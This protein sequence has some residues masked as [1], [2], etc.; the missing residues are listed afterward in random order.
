[1]PEAEVKQPELNSP[2]DEGA[3][4]N[5]PTNPEP[6][7]E[8]NQEEITSEV[9]DPVIA[10]KDKEI[11]EEKIINDKPDQP[12]A[13]P[14][15]TPKPIQDTP[16]EKKKAPEAIFANK[17]SENLFNAIKAGRKEDALKILSEQDRLSKLDNMKPEEKIKLN[18]QYQNKDFSPQEIEDLFEERYS[19]PEAPVQEP[20]ETDEEF[21]IVE[22]KYKEQLAR[23]ERKIEREAKASAT[24]LKKYAQELVLP[25]I[26][27]EA[28]AFKEPTQEELQMAQKQA[29][30]SLKAI[31]A[32]LT[33][34]KG[35]N[36]TF[37]DEEVE[38]PVAYKVT[39]QEKEDLKPLLNS[40]NTDLP[41]F[42]Q[43]LGWFDKDGKLDTNKVVT[44]IHLL[45]NKEDVFQ[46]LVNEAGNKRYKVAI[47]AQKNV[48]FN[49][50]I[51][52]G[53]LDPSIQEKVDKKVNDFMLS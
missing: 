35:Y 23:A 49:S 52:R 25:D 26:S 41:Q 3:W 14:G 45:K 16:D 44:D 50:Q 28:I 18:L 6:L 31:E 47:K 9:R 37:K 39:P 2:F 13:V 19:K 38:I 20:S 10:E 21:A 36:A 32:S 24:E 22:N 12:E 11:L 42:F 15:A 5:A 1:M 29:E 40:L 30:Q 4:R 17:E 34:L 27:Q 51:R 33:E 53:N 7:S 46:K 48:D 43:Q 8:D